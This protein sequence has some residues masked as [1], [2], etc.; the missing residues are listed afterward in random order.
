MYDGA[1][2]EVVMVVWVGPVSTRIA[3]TGRRGVGVVVVVVVG[4]VMV[5]MVGRVTVEVWCSRVRC[6]T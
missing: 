2:L 3:A 5:T 4:V 6:T 1:V